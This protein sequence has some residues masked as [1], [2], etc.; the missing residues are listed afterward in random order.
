MPSPR[1][2]CKRRMPSVLSTSSQWRARSRSFRVARVPTRVTLSALIRY[3]RSGQLAEGRIVSRR[4]L[5]LVIVAALRAVTRRC[6]PTSAA[7]SSRDGFR[8]STRPTT[9]ARTAIA[10]STRCCVAPAFRYGASSARS[11]RS[12]RRSRRWSSPATKTIPPPSRSTST[13]L[14]RCAV[15]SSA[16]A[17]S[18]R[19]IPSSPGRTTSRP[20]SARRC[21][22][23]GGDA[24]AAR[25]QRL[26]RGRRA[27]RRPDRLGLP[28]SKTARHA[29][30]RKPQGIVAVCV[31]LGRGEVIAITAP[32]LFGNAQL[33]NADNLRFAYNVIAGHGPRRLRRVRPR[34][35]RRA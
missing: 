5:E 16:A 20:A 18:S 24:I 12:I 3:A 4:T 22:T 19:S 29:A 26:H 17:V 31:S 32:A 13:T 35:Q 1:R 30:A 8:R 11:A 23:R 2:S 14:R 15:S 7:R 33:R 34:L 27:R 6:S 9:P 28:A 10:R 21:G 25:A